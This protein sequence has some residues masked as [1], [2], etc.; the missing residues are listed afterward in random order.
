[1]CYKCDKQNNITQQLGS[2]E[3]SFFLNS[4]LILV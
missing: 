3:F 2:I 4:D 1:M